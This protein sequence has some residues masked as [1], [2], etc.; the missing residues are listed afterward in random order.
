VTKW[1]FALETSVP[2]TSISAGQNKTAYNSKLMLLPCTNSHF[3]AAG[4]VNESVIAFCFDV[5]G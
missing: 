1:E 2:K 4:I 3:R 5:P